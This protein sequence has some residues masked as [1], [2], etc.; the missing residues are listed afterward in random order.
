[1]TL[2][3]SYVA[4][5]DFHLTVGLGSRHSTDR[6]DLLGISQEATRLIRLTVI[7]PGGGLLQEYLSPPL[8]VGA[9]DPDCL[10]ISGYSVLQDVHVGPV[11]ILRPRCWSGTGS[12]SKAPAKNVRYTSPF[13][14]FTQRRWHRRESVDPAARALYVG[15]LFGI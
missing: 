4:D 1:M 13:S 11:R 9:L 15:C 2:V 6:S 7:K 10:S 14:I 5:S 12:P 8:S 3:T